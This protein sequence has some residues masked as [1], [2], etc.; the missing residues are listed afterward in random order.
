MPGIPNIATNKNVTILI[1]TKT[2]KGF[3]KKFTTNIMPAPKAPRNKAFKTK[4]VTL[5]ISNITAI[6]IITNTTSILILFIN[7]ATIVLL[8][9]KPRVVELLMVLTCI[10]CELL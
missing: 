10:L 7:S 1:P 4:A 6:K 2:P 9:L 5:G 8:F 3:N